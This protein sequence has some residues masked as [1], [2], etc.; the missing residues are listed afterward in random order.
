MG[1]PA[2]EVTG[3]LSGSALMRDPDHALALIEATVGAVKVPVTLKMRMGWDERSLNA[4]AIARA[5][6][7][8]GVQMITVHGRTRCQFFKGR[9]DWDFIRQVKAAVSIPVIAN[10]DVASVAD[11]MRILEVSGADGVMI[12]RGAYGAPWL[13]ARVVAVLEGAADPGE[14]SARVQAQTVRTHYEAMLSFYGRELGR[15]NARK[16]LGWYV[17]RA[18][19]DPDQARR[20]RSALCREDEPERVLAGIGSLF[21]Q[22]EESGS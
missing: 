15:R 14:P 22:I 6:Q 13:F 7:G 12:G 20:W 9:A 1:C 19:K 16:H 17:E 18:V 3:K 10:G 2:R 11:A 5:A 4:P 21:A 8:A